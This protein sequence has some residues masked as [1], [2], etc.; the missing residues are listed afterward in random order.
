MINAV[1]LDSCTLTAVP[2]AGTW[3]S[4]SA[5]AP[6]VSV[7]ARSDSCVGRFTSV[8]S[9]ASRRKDLLV[10]TCI[11]PLSVLVIRTRMRRPGSAGTWRSPALPLMVLT[12]P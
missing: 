1:A 7:T 11:G 2:S 9:T 5:R 3:V 6:A 10:H 4:M 8:P 12:P